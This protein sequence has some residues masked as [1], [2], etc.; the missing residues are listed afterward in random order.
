MPRSRQIEHTHQFF[1]QAARGW[2]GR[3]DAN[4]AVNARK[5]QFL[6]ALNARI[7]PPADILDFGCGSG[8]IARHL[9]E[10]GYRV[11]GYDL[12]AA[13]IAEARQSDAGGRI[14][15]ITSPSTESNTLQMPDASF[16]AIVVSSVLEYVADLDAT[17]RELARVLRV[18]G[19]ILATV[20]DMRDPARKRETWLRIGAALPG[21]AKILDRS[22]WQEGAKYLR[23]SVNR[24][25]PEAWY[26]TMTLF[27]LV[28]DDIPDLAGPLLLVTAQKNTR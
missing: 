6:N 17:L 5:E 22:R 28:P 9:C 19:W 18:G 1:E 7:Q 13:M 27:K 10:A 2:N 14:N 20:P 24:L 11:T 23:I 26:D 3:Y 8:A 15:W 25:A 4:P 12:S 21:V 16:D